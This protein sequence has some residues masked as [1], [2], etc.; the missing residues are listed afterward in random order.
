MKG[1]EIRSADPENGRLS[2]LAGPWFP[3]SSVPVTSRL[4]VLTTDNVAGS[5]TAFL[6]STWILGSG[7]SVPV[8]IYFCSYQPYFQQS[9]CFKEWCSCWFWRERFQFWRTISALWV[10]GLWRDKCVHL[11]PITRSIF[12]DSKYI[13]WTSILVGSSCWQCVD[14]RANHLFAG[15]SKRSWAAFFVFWRWNLRFASNNNC[16]ECH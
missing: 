2:K 8:P 5:S 12:P 6:T 11:E 9:C 14:K 4:T 7:I 15:A 10:L 16:R 1:V 3:A 13:V